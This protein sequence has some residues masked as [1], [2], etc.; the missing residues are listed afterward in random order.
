MDLRSLVSPFEDV[1]GW[2]DLIRVAAAKGL[3]KASKLGSKKKGILE[4]RCR[5]PSMTRDD[6]LTKPYKS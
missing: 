5:Q 6:R 2:A 1:D 3:M 4:T